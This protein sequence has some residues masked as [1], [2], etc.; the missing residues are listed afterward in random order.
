MIRR[1]AA[2]FLTV[3]ALLAFNSPA[4]L[5]DPSQ[6]VG[7]VPQGF[8]AELKKFVAGTQE[9]K[10]GPW[11]HDPSCIDKG[12]NIGMYIN[13]VMLDEPRL[14]YWSTP[15][16]QRMAFWIT[17]PLDPP[18]DIDVNK[19]PPTL[20][21]LFPSSSKER[22][23]YL[24]PVGR[25]GCANTLREFTT[26]ANNAWGFTWAAA[27]DPATVEVMKTESATYP[28]DLPVD[29]FTSPCGEK[30]SPYCEKAFFTDCSKVAMNPDKLDM[31]Q[32]WD[33][34]VAQL[35]SGMA[36]Y[37]EN[38]TSWIDKVGDF[39]GLVGDGLATAGKWV[40][41]AFVSIVKFNLQVAK[42]VVDPASAVDDLAN[43]LH[44]AATSFTTTILQGLASVGNF[45]PSAPW[46]LETYAASTG[47]GVVVMAFMAI[48]M[49]ARTASGGGSREDLQESLFK[50]LPLGMFLA[51]FSPAIGALLTEMVSG[52]T[53]GIAAWDAGYLSSAMAKLVLIG[54][55]TV[56]LIPG[57]AFIGIIIF[58]LMIIG[59]FAV[60][61]GLAMQSI[62]LPL[63]AAVAGI[64]WGMWVHPKWRK[65]ALK[66]PYMFLG[67]LFAKPMLFFLLGII[68]ALIDG[69]L[70]VPAMKSGGL[71][72]LFQLILVAVALIV[73]GL[74]PFSLLKYSPLLPTAEDSHDSQPSSGFGTASV[75]G[76]GL[77][78]AGNRGGGGGK[79][80]GGGSTGGGNQ[81]SIQQNYGQQQQQKPPGGQPQQARTSSPVANAP[82]KS[83]PAGGPGMA[84]KPGAGQQQVGR[85]A[86]TGARGA[87]IGAGV[88]S[89]GA[90]AGTTGGLAKAAQAGGKALG[91]W[92][93]AAQV[94]V[95]G[96][97]KIRSAAHNRHAPEVD[98][99]V[100][101]GDQR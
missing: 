73:A 50:Q 99:E 37:I 57:G 64:A 3:L 13:A 28:A 31:C 78:A 65:K 59:A 27:P 94:A 70:S 95:A 72:L 30:N 40:V 32:H 22:D 29:K 36:A 46:F 91:P 83:G 7:N 33:M 68:F 48:L 43:S 8:P 5:A 88:G 97:N 21:K 56:T 101:R 60:F 98:G 38:N 77:A 84:G 100:I 44:E 19:E 81:H 14:M 6:P 12:G 45:D 42:F 55:V 79:D 66:V 74:A 87:P 2:L 71:A 49:I 93:V 89:G 82:G 58:L 39:F 20:P 15:P 51:V 25:G 85:T 75:V 90:V 54:G 63:S 11:F 34:S 96:A 9:F 26:P 1:I 23:V 76:A 61:V 18:K 67:V 86:A 92:A 53:N 4:A 80:G 62:A 52:L 16:D 17:N 47:I 41:D 69:N 35:F 10:D 24:M